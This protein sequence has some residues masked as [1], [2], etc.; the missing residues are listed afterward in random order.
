[1]FKEHLIE[2]LYIYISYKKT[3]DT[4]LAQIAR[5][6]LTE[7]EA[8]NIVEAAPI[9]PSTTEAFHWIIQFKLSYK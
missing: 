3:I 6:Q 7:N 2:K 8:K 9:N 4:V 1:M 5:L